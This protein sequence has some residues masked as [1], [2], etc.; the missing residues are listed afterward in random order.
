[1]PHNVDFSGSSF[2]DESE[3]EASDITGADDSPPGIKMSH[4]GKLLTFSGTPAENINAYYR[5]CKLIWKVHYAT[6]SDDSN[7]A[8]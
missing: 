5:T 4:P 1:M 3:S 6:D 8:V 2:Y 7:E